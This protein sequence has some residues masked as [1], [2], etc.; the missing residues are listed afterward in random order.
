M[1]NF[2]KVSRSHICQQMRDNVPL[3]LKRPQQF[4][5]SNPELY[6]GGPQISVDIR[7]WF[8]NRKPGNV[9]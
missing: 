7:I 3:S 6:I 4:T 2:T 8:L 5:K 9:V 1:S